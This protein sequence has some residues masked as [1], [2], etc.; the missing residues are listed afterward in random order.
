MTSSSIN[1]INGFQLSPQQKHL[2]LLQQL[3][4]DNQ[5]YRVQCSVSIEG[6]LNYQLLELVLRMV[7][8]KHEIFRTSFQTLKGMIIPLQVIHEATNI[9]NLSINTLNLIGIVT[10]YC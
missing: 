3:E 1:T 4:V 2:W 5:P 7:L 8:E 6:N 10:M 9:S